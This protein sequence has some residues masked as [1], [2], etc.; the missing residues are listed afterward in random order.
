[1]MLG[2][3]QGSNPF[4]WSGIYSQAEEEKKC[5]GCHCRDT[6]IKTQLNRIG[7]KVGGLLHSG[8]VE[9]CAALLLV[10]NNAANSKYY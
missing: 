2:Y 10:E 5:R 9:S 8:G 1:M 6:V 4:V 3:N 7:Y